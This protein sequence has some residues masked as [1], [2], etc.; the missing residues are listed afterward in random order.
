MTLPGMSF[1]RARSS[2]GRNRGFALVAL[3]GV[4]VGCKASYPE[5]KIGCDVASDC[6]GGWS[7]LAVA[8]EKR[9]FSSKD[10]LPE[11][12]GAGDGSVNMPDAARSDAAG[13]GDSG[14]MEGGPSD[15]GGDGGGAGAGSDPCDTDNGGCDSL[16][17]CSSKGDTVTCGACPARYDDVKGDGTKCTDV[18]E[19]ATGNGGCGDATYFTCTNQVGAAPKCKDIDECEGGA[20][21]ACGTG[22]TACTNTD[23]GYECTCGDGYSGT[24]TKA[25]ADLDA[26]SGAICTADYPCRDDAPP[27]LNYTCRGQFADWVPTF[28]TSAFSDTGGGFTVTDSR[29]GLEWQKALDGNTYAWADAKTYCADMSL[30]SLT[31]WRLPTKAELE[32]LVDDSTYNPAID[33]TH[34]PMTPNDAFWTASPYANS[35]NN[36]WSVKFGGGE[37]EYS[38]TIAT[39]L[40]VRC[41]R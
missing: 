15:A 10:A 20:V 16:V 1:V 19:C 5:G 39:A 37:S 14:S 17:E 9:C 38:N 36:A 31:D 28:S 34:F 18:D 12:G 26:C 24:G 29:N 25:C 21:A 23:G 22:A 11:D 3:F 33:T 8:G 4:L 30:A 27:S 35:V 6:P 32:S 13:A 2:C 41:V 7:C 40:R